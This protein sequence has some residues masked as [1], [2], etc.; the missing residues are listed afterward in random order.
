VVKREIQSRKPV[1]CVNL[2]MGASTC[3]P[4][5]SLVEFFCQLV[6]HTGFTH[7]AL[8]GL[9]A[10]VCFAIALT[11]NTIAIFYHS[12][13]AVP[14]GYI[15]AVALLWAFISFPLCLIG[16]VIGRNWNS[17]PNYPCR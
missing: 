17:V 13:A 3:P 12:L 16:T 15:L 10:G 9:L 5:Y 14:F 4:C 11:L 8:R 1:I 7:T 2:Y 6:Q